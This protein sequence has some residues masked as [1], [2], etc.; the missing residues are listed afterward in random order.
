MSSAVPENGSSR[1]PLLCLQGHHDRRAL[2]LKIKS[3]RSLKCGL[4]SDLPYKLRAI[5]IKALFVAWDGLSVNL[6]PLLSG[7]G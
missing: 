4:L 3:Q 7:P 1:A 2:G 6:L 5:K